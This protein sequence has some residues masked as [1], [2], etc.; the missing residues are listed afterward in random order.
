MTTPAPR[1]S[2]RVSRKASQFTE[3]VIREMTREAMK[4]GAVNLSQ[5]FPDFAAPED[6]KRVAMQAIADDVNQYAITWGAK[7]FRDAIA[8]KTTWYLGFEVDPETEITVTCGSTE[9]MISAMMSTVDPGEEVVVFEPFY[10]NYAPDAILSDATP[11]YVPLRA[12]DWTFD[13]SELRAAF[14]SKTKA[15]IICN[16]NNPTGKVFTREQMELIGG[17][18]RR[19]DALSF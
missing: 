18:C 1:I 16:P 10:E 7:D 12:P 6:V 3:S 5:G 2:R 8:K 9:G 14:N 17:F 19:C 15:I 13:A 11:R 4:Y